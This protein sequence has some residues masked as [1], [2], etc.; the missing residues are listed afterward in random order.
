MH[1]EIEVKVLNI[2]VGEIRTLL[3]R[4][5]AK[6]L[7]GPTLFREIFW[8]SKEKNPKYSVLRLRMEGKKSFLTLKVNVPSK[9]LKVRK[10]YEVEVSDFEMTRQILTLAGFI[11]S[12]IRE[13]YREAYRT[14]DVRIE[15]DRY[16]GVPSYLELE[17]KN[18]A[19]MR[20]FLAK[21][22]IPF[23]KTTAMTS[24]EVI[25]SAGKNPKRL[26]FGKTSLVRDL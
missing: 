24:S 7:F 14:R 9:N 19:V 13:K 2:N 17:G 21:L 11:E 5:G 8:K 4:A 20:K 1:K 10:E 18:E 22:G 26:V 23:S 6:K 15:I 12:Q 25:I 16:P 3:K